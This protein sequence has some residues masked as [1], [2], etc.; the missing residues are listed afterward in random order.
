[1]CVCLASVQDDKGSL[2]RARSYMQLP[3]V[4]EEPAEEDCKAPPCKKP[5]MAE[6]VEKALE[7]PMRPV[8]GQGN[9]SKKPPAAAGVSAVFGDYKLQELQVPQEAWPLEGHSYKGTKSYTVRS[10]S[11]AVPA[12]VLG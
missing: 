12:V 8:P 2:N 6:V 4:M 7:M 11:G 3:D 9:A 1:M 10:R 5:K